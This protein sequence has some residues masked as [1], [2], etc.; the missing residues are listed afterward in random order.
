[1]IIY[2]ATNKVNGKQYVGQ[3]INMLEKRRV[4]HLFD[5][6]NGSMYYFHKAIRKYG[7]DNFVWETVANAGIMCNL[8]MLEQI[9]IKLLNTFVPIGNRKSSIFQRRKN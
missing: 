1:M 8:N 7:E 9:Y 6:R 4:N 2:V 3:T 5:S